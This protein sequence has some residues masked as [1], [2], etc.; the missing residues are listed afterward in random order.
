MPTSMTRLMIPMRYRNTPDTVVPISPVVCCRAEPPSCTW[1]ASARTPMPSRRHRPNTTLEW[2]RENQNPT[3]SGRCRSAISL[4]VVLSIAAMW[5]ASN[6]C[7]M[8]RVYAVS[9]IP[10]PNALP[11]KLNRAG[12]TKSTRV[13][14]PTRCRATIRV[15]I[16][17]RRRHS[18]RDRAP[19][20]RD[21][22]RSSSPMA[23]SSFRLSTDPVARFRPPRAG[24]DESS[25][26]RGPFRRR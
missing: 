16:H 15:S 21:A 17:P 24:R 7:R 1:P 14:Q 9:P 6:A 26:G 10:I 3:D 5:S 8:P 20:D 23:T 12:S 25:T 4:R 2:P 18:A 13:L 22:R 19:D 11:P